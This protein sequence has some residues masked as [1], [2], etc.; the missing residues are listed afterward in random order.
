MDT[1]RNGFVI[2]IPDNNYRENSLSRI[3]CDRIKSY[4]SLGYKLFIID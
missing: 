4:L 3:I 2:R 1:I